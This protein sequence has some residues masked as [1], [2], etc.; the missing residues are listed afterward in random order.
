[1]SILNNILGVLNLLGQGGQDASGDSQDGAAQYGPYGPSS[2][3][4]GM[5]AN[6]GFAPTPPFLDPSQMASAP[7]SPAPAPSNDGGGI[8]LNTLLNLPANHPDAPLPQVPQPPTFAQRHPIWNTLL[9][10]QVP[11]NP[12]HPVLA[13]FL[14][15]IMDGFDA[16]VNPGALQARME[17]QNQQRGFPSR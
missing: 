10:G 6:P 16:K 17:R 8:D 7:A 9:T 3:Q 13:N 14:Q 5:S 2:R 15:G 4:P 12:N 1:M 11:Q